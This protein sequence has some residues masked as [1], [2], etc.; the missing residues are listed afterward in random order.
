MRKNIPAK[1]VGTAFSAVGAVPLLFLPVVAC[2]PQDSA[3]VEQPSEPAEDMTGKIFVS[4]QGKD[5]NPG[6]KEKPYATLRK[7]GEVAQPGDTVLLRGGEYTET[8][9]PSQSGL[10]GKT[11]RFA[12]YADEKVSLIAGKLIHG[13]QPAGDGVYVADCPAPLLGLGL[14]QV[15]CNG[16]LMIEARTPNTEDQNQLI[17]VFKLHQAFSSLTAE[18]SLRSLVST[19]DLR[20]DDTVHYVGRHGGAWGTQTAIGTF[21]EAG[22]MNIQN[23]TRQ[24]YLSWWLSKG[25]G[26]VTGA[27][28]YLDHAREWYVDR[29]QGKIYFMPPQGTDVNTIKVYLKDHD[30]AI[31]LKDRKHIEIEGI[32]TLMGTVRMEKSEDCTVRACNLLYGGHHSFFD[33][34][35]VYEGDISTK[36][37]V[38]VTGR[39]NIIDRCQVAWNAGASIVIGGEDNRVLN[40]RIHDS[41]LL[42]SY[43]SGIYIFQEEKLQ[44][45]GHEIAQNTI[46]NLGRGA[47]HM[48]SI[49]G[50]GDP[51]KYAKPLHIHHNDISGAMMICHDGGAI[52][53]FCT[54][55]AG[56]QLH[57]N[58]ITGNNGCS[59]YFDNHSFGWF[60]HHNVIP[61][62]V[63][64]NFPA[65]RIHIYNNTMLNTQY[66][67]SKYF[68][69]K[70]N[71]VSHN[72]DTYYQGNATWDG[73]TCNG[74]RP[75]YVTFAA[76]GEGGLKYR[77]K[78]IM[79]AGLPK[80][81]PRVVNVAPET[82]PQFSS[83][84][85][86]AYAY[87]ESA[88]EEQKNWVAGCDW[89][90]TVPKIPK[91]KETPLYVQAS[92]FSEREG[93]RNNALYVDTT[94]TK[95]W[96][97]YQ[98]VDLSSGYSH[99]VFDLMIEEP[100]P[101]AVIE[102][103]LDALDGE[104]VARST[105]SYRQAD[106]FQFF[107]QAAKLKTL[108]GKHDLFLV[109]Q[110]EKKVRISQ[111]IFA[112]AGAAPIYA[113][114]PVE[115]ISA[116]GNKKIE[117]TAYQ[118]GSRLLVMSDAQ[119][120][121]P[122][123]WMTGSYEVR[124]GSEGDWLFFPRVDLGPEC[125]QVM[126]NLGDRKDYD[127]PNPR[128]E[129][130]SGTP[131]GPLLGSIDIPKGEK[132][133]WQEH[134]IELKDASGVHD[135]FLVL[136]KKF[137]GGVN[138]LLFP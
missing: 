95:S 48:A 123:T 33:N 17:Y 60:V 64:L 7:A 134:A 75:P 91:L 121:P 119:F 132:E 40:S 79:E 112:G 77:V 81:K 56:S 87:G 113:A 86:G 80:V 61:N 28:K 130:R 47:I 58:W 31:D 50:W 78:E 76:Q 63:N 105:V 18:N 30:V 116:D 24:G 46:Y 131:D 16:E 111:L 70:D 103:R 44:G 102:L 27:K 12:R 59:I 57:H 107:H 54:D 23:R 74:V 122:G 34:P 20:T 97:R 128:L 26:Y 2:K 120:Q 1:W 11:I 69:A 89:G 129:L 138:Y 118:E 65:D 92:H 100:M 67:V 25:E 110:A 35:Y 29:N 117:K 109:I 45:G 53:Q 125:K 85:Y 14:N 6:T 41:G 39:G 133:K 88:P 126:V 83:Q 5:D 99:V 93:M 94:S 114:S 96:A 73:A 124:G 21:D 137:D 68:W 37:G 38:Y 3:R 9:S 115:L 22:T 42:G 8:L 43:Y 84:Y 71:F 127:D 62:D 36:S 108:Q 19:G 90:G 15:V 82:L 13:W 66:L 55:G 10:P 52:Y 104:C 32:N 98:D 49:G 136:P 51:G 4:P 72:I 135:L 101:D 106:N